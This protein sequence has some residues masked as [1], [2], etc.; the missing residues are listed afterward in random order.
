[1]KKGLFIGIFKRAVSM[2]LVVIIAGVYTSLFMPKRVNADDSPIEIRTYTE[3]CEAAKHPDGN[4]ILMADIDL[5]KQNDG[6][7]KP[8]N[9]S[10]TFDGNGHTIYNLRINSTTSETEKTYDGNLKS[11]DTHFAG[12][13]GILKDATIKNLGIVG[14]YID[15][16]SKEHT[17]VGTI[18][19]Y[20]DNSTISNCHVVTSISL[21][22]SEKMW[23]VGGILGFGN[24]LIEESTV[25]CTLVSID[26][27]LTVKD[28]QFMG[29]VYSDGYAEV[30]NCHVKIDGYISDHGYVHSGGVTGLYIVYPKETGFVG[31]ISGNNIDG[32][33]TF[34]EDNTDR[35][36][37]CR[38]VVGETMSAHKAPVENTD[39]FVRNEVFDYSTDLK[40]HTCE[41]A[42]YTTTVVN[43]NCP[44]YGYV[45]SKCN[46][47]G[48]T[49]K[50]SYIKPVHSLGEEE[51]VEGY[52]VE[53]MHLTKGV[54]T[55]CNQV[56]YQEKSIDEVSL[57]EA[58]N[59]E[60]TNDNADNIN[61]NKSKKNVIIIIAVTA[62][63][64]VAA[65][66]VVLKVNV[67]R[68]RRARQR[69]R[70][71]FAK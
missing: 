38:A 24:G 64:I 9:F 1:M 46:Q 57:S 7:W 26:T 19:G 25:D 15:V 20:M 3:L 17:M 5:D 29:G 14:G 35:R 52:N 6:Y 67:D 32:M 39:S 31:E 59:G 45:L 47:C 56:I 11:Y 28:E 62:V 42:T 36:A 63:I 68:Q 55:R 43:N 27:N 2:M 21:T 34:F 37:Y 61:E 70:R 60:N 66:L 16:T 30:K 8:W 22:C 40:P 4:Y 51:K 54:C 65:V 53:Y 23:G 48:Y 58:E 33:I 41:N 71:N 44:D 10:G 13:F 50:S 18:A 12:F 69:R 49:Y